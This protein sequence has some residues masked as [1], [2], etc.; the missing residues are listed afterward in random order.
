VR[1]QT[2][3]AATQS[4]NFAE[5]LV[6]GMCDAGR[7]SAVRL[8]QAVGDALGI[9]ENVALS[10]LGAVRATTDQAAHLAMSVA[11][12]AVGSR[13]APGGKN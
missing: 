6:H 1:G 10:A 11:E 2:L 13:R 5:Q 4:I 9:L 7:R 8:D 12:G 3:A